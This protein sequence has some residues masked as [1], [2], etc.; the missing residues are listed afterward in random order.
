MKNVECLA[1]RC[2]WVLAVVIT[3]FGVQ[4]RAADSCDISVIPEEI[5]TK[6]EKNYP[7]WLPERLEHLYDEDRQFW[8]KDHPNECPGI[9][10]GH[11]ESRR[12]RSYALLLLSKPGRKKDFA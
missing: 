2:A 9:A 1:A 12:E 6:L 7:D 8:I 11:F 3:G 5:R 10:I 4:A